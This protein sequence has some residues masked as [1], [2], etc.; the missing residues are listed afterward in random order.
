[1]TD[2]KTLTD[3]AVEAQETFRQGIWYAVADGERL[4]LTNNEMGVLLQEVEYKWDE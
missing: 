3:E 4:G 2:D 1:M